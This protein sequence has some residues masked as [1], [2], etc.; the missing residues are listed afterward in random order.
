MCILKLRA[1]IYSINCSQFQG[2]GG[3]SDLVKI[4]QY[5]VES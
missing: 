2:H 1:M 4:E 3:N 5:E